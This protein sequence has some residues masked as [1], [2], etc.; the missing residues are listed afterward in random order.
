M[1]TAQRTGR[2]PLSLMVA[3]L[4]A[5]APFTIDTYLPSFPDIARELAASPAQMQLTLSLYLL[6]AA[7]STLIYGPLSDGF[8][9]RRVI[10]SAL[11]IYALASI[12]CALAENINQLILLRIGQGLSASAGMVIGRAMI[13]DVYHGTEARRVM[14]RVTL[15]FSIAPA[16]A[17]I[18]GGW[19]HDI[20]GWHSVF[21]FLALFAVVLLL[22]IWRGTGETLAMD[23]RHSVHPLAI[24][25]AYGM[26][27]RNRHYLALVF[28][29]AM[30][31]SGFF[32]YVAGAPSVIYGFLGLG[33]NDFWVM[34]VP[35]VAA[36][37]LGSQIAGWLA[38]RL[39]SE[40]TV[41]LGFALLLPA[42]LLNIVQSLLLAPSPLYVIAPLALYVLGMAVSMPNI[43]LMALDRFPHNRGMASAMQSFVQMGFTALVVGALVPLLT[44]ALPYMALAMFGLS[45]TGLALWL[46]R[47]R[48]E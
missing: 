8:G 34:F 29:F 41:W 44:P 16:V 24:A 19:M 48:G 9:R 11:C 17:P 7:I 30:M 45:L 35:I 47:G 37:M 27:L 28:S 43:N 36:I 5:L 31:F 33:A 10:M 18:L 42:S 40:Q 23:K 14:A 4:A 15:L 13:R 38:A 39:T 2:V 3:G 6:A 32:I 25:R 26:A 1:Q 20:F 22:M 46:L 12:G 21:L